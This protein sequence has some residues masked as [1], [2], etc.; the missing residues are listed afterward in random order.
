MISRDEGQSRQMRGN[1]QAQLDHSP[2]A[3]RRYPVH[4]VD[5][6][7]VVIEK[8]PVERIYR[9]VDCFF[10]DEQHPSSKPVGIQVRPLS[11]CRDQ[12]HQFGGQKLGRFDI[13]SQRPEIPRATDRRDGIVG[14]VS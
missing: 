2:V 1:T 14:I 8:H 6:H 11:W 4:E 5:F 7:I 12:I 13:D 9:L 10:G 3:D